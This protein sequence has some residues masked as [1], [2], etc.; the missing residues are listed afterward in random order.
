MTIQTAKHVLEL[1]RQKP[2]KMRDLE[3]IESSYIVI[4]QMRIWGI[5]LQEALT[6]SQR[7]KG[8]FGK[9]PV[10]TCEEGFLENQCLAIG[11]L[12]R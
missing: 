4:D 8:Q 5:H 6:E 7:M 2:T 3:I 12:S 10:Y 11:A 1:I 9:D